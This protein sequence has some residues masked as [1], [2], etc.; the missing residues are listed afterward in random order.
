MTTERFC[1]WLQG[2]VEISGETPNAQQ[3]E[4]IKEHLGLVFNKV[5]NKTVE[6]TNKGEKIESEHQATLN[7]LK[8]WEVNKTYPRPVLNDDT[9]NKRMC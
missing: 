2:Y 7:R 4:V 5:T 9:L 3:W 6:P 1:D 8:E